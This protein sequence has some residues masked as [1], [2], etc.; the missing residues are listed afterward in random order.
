[1]KI[2]TNPAFI[3]WVFGIIIVVLLLVFGLTLLTSNAFSYIPINYRIIVGLFILSYGAFRL[4][5]IYYKYKS[6]RDEEE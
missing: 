4:V 1:M 3:Y 2:F 6:N 5:N